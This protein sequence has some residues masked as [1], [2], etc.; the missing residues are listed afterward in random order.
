MSLFENINNLKL[1]QNLLKPPD[2]SSDSEEDDRLPPAGSHKIGE[3]KKYKKHTKFRILKIHPKFLGP[4][5]IGTNAKANPKQENF[6]KKSIVTKTDFPQNIEEWEKLQE[7]E[8]QEVLETRKR[9]EYKILYKQAVTTE[10]IYL[11][12][13]NK[14]AATMSC[15]D[16]VIQIELPAE[17]VGIEEM[18]LSV[19]KTDIDLKT[20][21][22]RLRLP[23]T[24]TINPDKGKAS[25][26]SETKI[27]TLTLRMDREFDYVNF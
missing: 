5:N 9:P 13:G 22:Y 14:N 4:A 8:N 10:D 24:H 23:L 27:L 18:D 6:P 1:L 20:S 3:Y 2:E 12:M 15:E 7:E 19:T 25:Y 26:N 21:I 16:M 11:Q 17:I